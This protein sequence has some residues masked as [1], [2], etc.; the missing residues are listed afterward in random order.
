MKA[1]SILWVVGS[2]LISVIVLVLWP[3]VWLPSLLTSIA[4]GQGVQDLRVHGLTWRGDGLYVKRLELVWPDDDAQFN[5]HGDNLLLGFPSFSEQ[6]T[7]IQIE[8]LTVAAVAQAIPA[9]EGQEAEEAEEADNVNAIMLPHLHVQ[10]DEIQYQAATHVAEAAQ[11][12]HLSALDFRTASQRGN[13]S[14][15]IWAEEREAIAAQG[16]LE[17]L[18]DLGMAG[19]ELSLESDGHRFF[20]LAADRVTTDP[21][22]AQYALDGQVMLAPEGASRDF[23]VSLLREFSGSNET[24]QRLASVVWDWQVQGT[25]TKSSVAGSGWQFDV[26]HDIE[27]Q[28]TESLGAVAA[29]GVLRTVGDVQD[30]TLQ[31]MS[32]LTLSTQLDLEDQLQT[33]IRLNLAA[34]SSLMISGSRV[35][36]VNLAGS[37][38]GSHPETEAQANFA[39]DSLVFDL[40]KGVGSLKVGLQAS[41]PQLNLSS[42][43]L[44]FEASFGWGDTRWSEGAFKSVALALH[45]DF[46]GQQTSEQSGNWVLELKTN[47]LPALLQRAQSLTDVFED[48]ELGV[49]TLL[50]RHS[51]ALSAAGAE[52]ALKLDLLDVSGHY[53][54][55]RFEGMNVQALL[56]PKY[57]WHSVQ[58]IAVYV[59]RLEAVYPIF[60]VTA[61]AALLPDSTQREKT[62]QIK[63]LRMNT[64]DGIVRSAAEFDLALETWEA[65]VDLQLEDIRLAHMLD[66]YGDG[67]LE[68]V[69]VIEGN[70]PVSVRDDDI[71]INEGWAKNKDLGG[72]IRY[73]MQATDKLADGH[74]QANFAFRLLT[75]FNYSDLGAKLSLTPNGDLIINLHLD[76]H[77]PEVMDGQRVVFNVNVEQNI[78]EMV[79]TWRMTEQYLNA[80]GQRLEKNRTNRN[81]TDQNGGKVDES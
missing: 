55:Y 10:I 26:K 77:N 2:L 81:K 78:F 21:G 79:K 69:G 12:L 28:R 23:I 14:V 49:G 8:R 59:G 76:G 47:E 51:L 56:N 72:Y 41:S 71:F 17:L 68:A 42:V 38:D 13:F 32:P 43:D 40:A 24:T 60:D 73:R 46:E 9:E 4:S 20:R 45:G 34:G 35:T 52:Q 27:I 22:V 5:I 57:G 61:A 70:L 31:V 7:S 39:V 58:D 54:G 36:T 64:L 18:P 74:E 16:W 11:P 62:L 37:V 75:D 53:D 50:L 80:A 19:G 63:H 30:I 67:V 25:L 6:P 3:S 1:K 15:Q 48:L 65:D 29:A 33:D 44:S 66:L